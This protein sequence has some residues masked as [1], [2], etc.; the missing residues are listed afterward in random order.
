MRQRKEE[1]GEEEEGEEDRLTAEHA[2]SEAATGHS[3]VMSILLCMQ[4]GQLHIPQPQVPI[5]GARHKQLATGTEGA[6]HHGGVTHSCHPADT[7]H[8]H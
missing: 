3:Q 7:Q 8:C 1:R 4:L 2:G 6:G 5:G